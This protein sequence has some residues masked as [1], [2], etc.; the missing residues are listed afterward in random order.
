MPNRAMEFSLKIN[1]SMSGNLQAQLNAAQNAFNTF[2]NS[3]KY[4]QNVGNGKFATQLS[5]LQ[6]LQ[7]KIQAYK[8]SMREVPKLQ[9]QY[10]ESKQK[11]SQAAT[12]RKDAAQ[13]VANLKIQLESLQAAQVGLK[14]TSQ[15]YKN[16][17]EQIKSTKAEIKSA[18]DALKT[19]ETN[20]KA[21]KIQSG[22]IG[23]NLS[24]QISQL[25]SLRSAL[26][27]A[28]VGLNSLGAAE[29]RLQSQINSTNSALQRQQDLAGRRMNF[30]A[31]MDN[32]SNSYSNFQNS[33]GTAQTI[34]SPFVDAARNAMDFEYEMANVKAL[35][36]LKNIRA[37]NLEQVNAEMTSMDKQF[38][39]LG[40]ST[41]YT[42]LN[43]AQ[44]AGYFAMAGW[45][46]QKI[47]SVMPAFVNLATATSTSGAN[48]ARLADVFSDD[49]TA[50]GLQAGKMVTLKDNTQVEASTYFADAFAY[51]LTNANLNT[52][53]LHEATK[54]FGPVAQQMGLSVAEMM[55]T[56]MWT[57][58]AGIKGS[59]MGTAFRAGL[60]RMVAPTK[61]AEGA[62]A[63]MGLT[64]SDAQ[65]EY[66]EAQ[67]ALKE[68]GIQGET[69]TEKIRGM[70]QYLSTQSAD[71]RADFI[72]KVFGKNAYSAWAK[73]L[74]NPEAV[75]EIAKQAE[76]MDSSQV[77]GYANE[78]AAIKRDSTHVQWEMAKS[79]LDA[80]VNQIGTALLPSI[81]QIAQSVSSILLPF[82]EWISQNQEL[83][84][85]VASLAAG[86]STV[87]VAA[88]GIQ[89]VAAAWGMV[90]ASATLASGALGTALTFL[91]GLS[92]ASVASSLISGLGT[93]FMALSRAAVFFCATPVGL[94]L[95]AIALAAAAIYQ[96][97]EKVGPFFRN[98]GQMI[99]NAFKN[100]FPAVSALIDKVSDFFGIDFTGGA[101]ENK[102]AQYTTNDNAAEFKATSAAAMSRHRT[103]ASKEEIAAKVSQYQIEDLQK[104]LPKVEVVNR[105][106]K[107]SSKAEIEA[108]TQSFK[109]QDLQAQNFS[110]VPGA[111]PNSNF[112][113][114]VQTQNTLNQPVQSAIQ[115][116]NTLDTSNVQSQLDT[117]GN[118]AQ[119]NSDAMNQNAMNQQNISAATE[120]VS[121]NMTNAAMAASQN[122][123]AET[124]NSMA[125]TQSA[126]A[127][128]QNAAAVTTMT[129][130][131]ANSTGA[132]S[133]MTTSAASSTGAISSLS[134]S[135]ASAA[136]S[137]SG[138][139]AA[140]MGAISSIG[141][142]ISGAISSVASFVGIGNNYSGG[143]YNQGAFLTWFAEK[144]PEAAIPLDGS[145]RAISLWQ[146]AGQILGV[147]P[148]NN[149]SYD[150]APNFNAD[151]NIFKANE[152][153]TANL[154]K[155][156]NFSSLFK[157]TTPN[158]NKANFKNIFNSEN[159]A[160]TSNFADSFKNVF[161]SE[162]F[163]GSSSFADSFKNVFNSENFS[164]MFENVFRNFSLSNIAENVSSLLNEG[165][166]FP[167]T[168]NFSST[169]NFSNSQSQ[170]SNTF[171]F[172]F[173]ITTN[174]G[175]LDAAG[176]RQNFENEFNNWMEDFKRRD[177]AW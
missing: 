79:A 147:Y 126:M 72:N 144:S 51:A 68:A 134:S 172:T 69:F 109:Q 91:R 26:S 14:R 30:S 41:E 148:G 166:T 146:Q 23:S 170:S 120:N 153:S 29:T 161:N 66:H 48:F 50:V 59:Q 82:S 16:L 31:S 10:L 128:T 76:I 3:A 25:N 167:S 115:T 127:S 119:V 43:I 58:N 175:N 156:Q 101:G 137:L 62:L 33:V 117:L 28:G 155:N 124:Q 53:S 116:Q 97:W 107:D 103:D 177:F 141:G 136:G 67:A 24:R 78:T 121:M 64:M 61:G 123:M 13:K 15:E 57:A 143:I 44:A 105:H 113:T 145:Q 65:K 42:S 83:V 135:S 12:E 85:G 22:D 56:T 74:E 2:K 17:Q 96:N 88:A 174:G 90:T 94:A 54:Y 160:G 106:R 168:E 159:F 11:T 140:V 176:I 87:I 149:F 35:T 165:G 86:I 138:F 100:A 84:L 173:N 89:L 98:I 110:Q 92:F 70:A 9:R 36:Q 93:A 21:S 37:G 77:L 108:Q 71:E 4:T 49:M 55:A 125:A 162:N 95:T 132:I 52:E 19:A 20:F 133:A 104:A 73:I 102:L 151:S 6:S 171:N 114:A 46:V 38:R 112:Q 47:Q 164:S 118:S 142:A 63:E 139:G 60:I 45:D 163:A 18:N 157:V 99:Y 81:T 154:N 158:L 34:M 169:D 32:M 130:S 75:E 152:I 1:A 8:D 150:S 27:S 7:Q 111:I 39:Q 131:A 40:A 5:E 80:V 122:A 129:A